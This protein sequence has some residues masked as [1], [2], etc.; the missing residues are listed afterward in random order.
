MDWKWYGDINTCRLFIHLILS[1]N[2][3]EKIWKNDVIKA[4]EI[5]TSTAHLSMQTN[6]SMSQVRTALKKLKDS[7]V[8]EVKTTNKYTKISICNWE[9][10]Q[11]NDKQIANKSQTDDKQIAT[12]KERKER[13]EGKKEKKFVYGK[14]GNVYLSDNEFERLK[15]EFS[16]YEERIERLS[17]Y[18]ES[19]GKTYKNH[20]ATVCDWAK[21]EKPKNEKNPFL[22][23]LERSENNDNKGNCEAFGSD[24]SVLSKI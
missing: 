17:V 22:E 11:S 8:I 6:L 23:L 24:F 4:G 14:F 2:Y 16:D 1:A 3:K 20:Y 19:T 12:T 21:R 13:K 10:Y 18:M 15:Q 7:Q 9:M 5:I